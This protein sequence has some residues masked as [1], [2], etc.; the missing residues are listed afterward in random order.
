MATALWYRTKRVS[1]YDICF[2]RNRSP[3]ELVE[4]RPMFRTSQVLG[5]LMGKKSGGMGM[6]P[7][8][9]RSV[10]VHAPTV[11]LVHG[12]PVPI[13]RGSQPFI[14]P[15]HHALL[16]DQRYR[17]ITDNLQARRAHFIQ[18]VLRRVPERIVEVDDVDRMN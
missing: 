12:L 1:L 13:E 3:S 16:S 17:H 9:E 10:T 18:R 5:D 4:S 7:R 14:A 15:T 6:L 8:V 2:D 11:H